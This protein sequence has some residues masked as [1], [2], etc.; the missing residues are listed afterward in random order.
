LEAVVGLGYSKKEAEK[1][2]AKLPAE[3]TEI[4]AIVRWF[5]QNA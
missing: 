2:L 1:V 4:E 5:L 3:I